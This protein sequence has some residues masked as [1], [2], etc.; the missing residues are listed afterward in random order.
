MKAGDKVA[1]EPQ[2]FVFSPR[3]RGVANP[4]LISLLPQCPQ[5]FLLLFGSPIALLPEHQLAL[6]QV[7]NCF[8]NQIKCKSKITNTRQQRRSKMIGCT[9]S[10]PNA[11]QREGLWLTS[12]LPELKQ[13]CVRKSLSTKVVEPPNLAGWLFGDGR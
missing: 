12:P 1:S 2:D 3:E 4:G 5:T 13:H 9:D 7:S 6:P 10:K 8:G 11:G